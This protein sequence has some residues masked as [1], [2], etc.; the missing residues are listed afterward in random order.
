MNVIWRE[1]AKCECHLKKSW[2]QDSNWVKI[3]TKA[4]LYVKRSA[5][6]MTWPCLTNRN[7][8]ME[9]TCTNQKRVLDKHMQ[10]RANSSWES[11]AF[12]GKFLI[13]FIQFIMHSTMPRTFFSVSQ[14]KHIIVFISHHSSLIQAWLNLILTNMNKSKQTSFTCQSSNQHNYLN[15]TW[16]SMKQSSD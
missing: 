6:L 4:R 2:S 10:A 12:S 9:T 11:N 1:N 16:I 14:N 3:W 8:H 5:S 15:S 13:I 7:A